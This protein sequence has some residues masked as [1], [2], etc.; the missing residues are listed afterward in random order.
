MYLQTVSLLWKHQ[1]ITSQLDPLYKQ[2]CRSQFASSPLPA[3]SL[4][5]TMYRVG[6]KQVYY[7]LYTYFWPTLYVRIL[8]VPRKQYMSLTETN[9]QNLMVPP[10]TAY[11]TTTY[12]HVHTICHREHGHLQNSLTTIFLPSQVQYNTNHYKR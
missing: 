7:I 3:N 8:P 2:Y 4:I 11:E 12:K 10:P 5:V 1:F 6:H 9:E